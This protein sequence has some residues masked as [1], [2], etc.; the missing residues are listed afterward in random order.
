MSDDQRDDHF[1]PEEPEEHEYG[2]LRHAMIPSCAID[3][4]RVSDAMLRVL[5]TLGSYASQRNRRHV[6]AK[7]ATIAKRLGCSRQAVSDQVLALESL[8]YVVVQ[9][10]ARKD[11]GTGTNQLRLAMDITVPDQYVREWNERPRKGVGGRPKR[12]STVGPTDAPCY[13]GDETDCF[14]DDATPPVKGEL[15]SPVKVELTGAKLNGV[16]GGETQLVD[17]VST[18]LVDGGETPEVSGG[19][20]RT[21]V[22][23]GDKIYAE[24]MSEAS[25]FGAHTDLLDGSSK[26]I[27]QADRAPT[28]ARSSPPADNK[29]TVAESQSAESASAPVQQPQFVHAYRTIP[30][31]APPALPTTIGA[32]ERADV[33]RRVTAGVGGGLLGAIHHNFFSRAR[34][35]AAPG[36]SWLLLAH[37]PTALEVLSRFEDAIRRELLLQTRARAPVTLSLRTIHAARADEEALV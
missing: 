32:T 7:Q 15:T 30:V 34:L 33:W 26:R 36:G 21:P 13:Y 4:V 10:T 11:H 12:V 35:F 23:S 8:G 14:T 20:R 25:S 16:D 2:Y 28:R 6:W 24:G 1:E 5:I 37:S 27:S 22:A 17:G 31:S 19:Y 9:R 18:Q 3:D 29:S